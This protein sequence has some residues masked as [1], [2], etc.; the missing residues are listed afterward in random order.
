MKK[1]T[2]NDCKEECHTASPR[3]A[4]S[5]PYCGAP[6]YID[7]L[8]TRNTDRE[9]SYILKLISKLRRIQPK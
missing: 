1:I 5:C 3:Y 2:C 8:R 6:F 9:L 7:L 4:N